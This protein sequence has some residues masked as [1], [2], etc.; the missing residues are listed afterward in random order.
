MADTVKVQVLL[1]GPRHL[2]VNLT[3]LSD[4]TGE[5]N[6]NKVDLSATSH[7]ATTA[8]GSAHIAQGKSVLDS[9]SIV[10]A[11]Y[12]IQGFEGVKLT[13]DHTTDSTSIIMP[14]GDG[15]LDYRDTGGLHDDGSGGTGDILL[16]TISAGAGAANDTYN[17]KLFLKK[18]W[19]N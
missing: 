3:N 18:K 17:I 6:V 19:G 16:S 14:A 1:D 12:S 7:T 2:V 4:G 13:W 5:T 8:A 15:Y 9:L 11:W 10:E